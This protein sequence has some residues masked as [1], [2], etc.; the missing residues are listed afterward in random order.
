MISEEEKSE[1]GAKSS[2]PHSPESKHVLRHSP[3]SSEFCLNGKVC[4][5]ENNPMTDEL[6]N[7]P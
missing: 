6:M 2:S 1:G 7:A 3:K 5:E 4:E